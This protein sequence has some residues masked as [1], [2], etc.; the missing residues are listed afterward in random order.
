MVVFGGC[1]IW[2]LGFTTTINRGKQNTPH[3]PPRA[4]QIF[5]RYINL[6]VTFFTYSL[7]PLSLI[8]SIASYRPTEYCSTTHLPS[9]YVLYIHSFIQPF[10]PSSIQKPTSP[11]PY[12]ELYPHLPAFPAPIPPPPSTPTTSHFDP[13][14]RFHGNVNVETINPTI[15]NSSHRLR[16]SRVPGK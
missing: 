16:L 9:S 6:P 14:D 3:Q 15:T 13:A 1:G 11:P 12:P 2:T 7:Q 4:S 10:P 5:P 8:P